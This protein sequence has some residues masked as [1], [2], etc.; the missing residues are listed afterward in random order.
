VRLDNQANEGH[1]AMA[2]QGFALLTPFLWHED[3]AQ[4]RLVSLFPDRVSTRNWAYWLAY[5]EERRMTP[6]I[7]RFREWLLAELAAGGARS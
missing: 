7:K 5:P 3:L 4:G 2:G 6:K 1:A